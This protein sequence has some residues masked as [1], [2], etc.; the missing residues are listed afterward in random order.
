MK[1]GEAL[2]R[3]AHAGPA[4]AGPHTRVYFHLTLSHLVLKPLKL[5]R[6]PAHKI[7]RRC[8]TS[9]SGLVSKVWYRIPF[10]QSK[11]YV[12]EIPPTDSP[13]VRP[14]YDP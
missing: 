3:G 1:L 7:P 12:S 13:K 10:D 14:G 11:L 4:P 5:S 9:V 8:L 2:L 6:V